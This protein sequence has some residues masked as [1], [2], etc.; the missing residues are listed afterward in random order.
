MPKA[1]HAGLIVIIPLTQ[2]EKALKVPKGS[3]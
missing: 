3:V 1:F 2:K